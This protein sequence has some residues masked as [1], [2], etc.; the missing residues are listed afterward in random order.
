MYPGTLDQDF[1]PLSLLTFGLD[2]SLLWGALLHVIKCFVTSLTLTHR[3]PELPTHPHSVLTTKVSSGIAKASS[4]RSKVTLMEKHDW[5]HK[6]YIRCYQE[7]LKPQFYFY[8]T[9]SLCLC[10]MMMTDSFSSEQE[11]GFS[12]P[13][14]LSKPR[15]ECLFTHIFYL[16]WLFFFP[17]TVTRR[18]KK[19]DVG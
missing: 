13:R 8:R 9:N 14:A 11:T 2:H 16:F 1:S 15:K 4:W 17:L 19:Y 18:N 10:L 6:E 12:W 3:M 7:I 5:R